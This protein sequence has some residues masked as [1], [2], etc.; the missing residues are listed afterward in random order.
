VQGPFTL[1]PLPGLRSSL[2]F[3]VSHAEAERI[4]MLDTGALNAEIER[5]SHSVLGKVAVEP[6]QGAFALSTASAE[7]FAKNRVALIGEAAHRVPPIGA[8][9]LNLGLRDAAIIAEIAGDILARG[10][11]IGAP[12]ATRLYDQRRRTDIM[13]RVLAVDA[14]NRSLLSDFLGLQSIRG[15]GLYLLD[16]MGPFR[17]A[18]MREGVAPAV[19]RP[20]LMQENA[21]QRF[22]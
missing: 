9:G 3:V 12:S 10:G 18:L 7:R 22:T 16:R 17:R 11:D 4:A 6:G 1:V 19:A 14:L 8:Q 21:A 2:V 5:R 13:S 20:R 15:L